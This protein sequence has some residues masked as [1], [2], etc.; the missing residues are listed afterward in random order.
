MTGKID[1]FSGDLQKAFS[2]SRLPYIL[3][4]IWCHY[5]LTTECGIHINFSY[6][7][8][9]KQNEEKKNVRVFGGHFVFSFRRPTEDWK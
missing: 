2:D 9:E 3:R 6:R 1:V 5:S 8:K 4:D 7:W